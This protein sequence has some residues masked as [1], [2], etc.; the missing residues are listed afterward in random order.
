MAWKVLSISRFRRTLVLTSLFML[1]F[2]VGSWSTRCTCAQDGFEVPTGTPR[3]SL[4]YTVPEPVGTQASSTSE[5]G[6]VTVDSGAPGYIL[7][8]G[9]VNG[10]DHEIDDGW[11]SVGQHFALRVNPNGL[12]NQWLRLNRG[13][14]FEI[15]FREFKRVQPKRKAP[16]A[17]VR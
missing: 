13:K 16:E 2:G 12:P 1:F 14:E 6:T 11:W 5:C 15:V 10:A 7:Q 9:E 4:G 3:S 8:V 17:I